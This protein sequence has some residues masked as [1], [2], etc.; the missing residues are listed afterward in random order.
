[1]DESHWLG[2]KPDPDNSFGFI[3]QITNNLTGR[4]YIGR[5]QYKSIR[6]TRV[7]GQRR[8]KVTHLDSG[9]ETYTGSSTSLNEDIQTLGKE[10]FSFIIL[11]NASSRSMLRWLEVKEIVS[12][13]ALLNPNLYYNGQ[14]DAIKHRIAP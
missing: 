3:Y 7:A 11:K 1:M 4:M 6:R 8:R 2:I 14:V 13:E 10:N 5:K 12:R 9:W